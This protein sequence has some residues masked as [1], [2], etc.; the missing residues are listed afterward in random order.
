MTQNSENEHNTTEGGNSEQR[1]TDNIVR[2][3]GKSAVVIFL[4]TFLELGISLIT[5]LIIAQ[6]LV[7]A[8]YGEVSIGLTILLVTSIVSQLG[9]DT[10]IPRTIPRYEG[11]DRRGVFISAF[12]LNAI[13]SLILAGFVFIAA[14]FIADLLGNPA[15]KSVLRVVAFGVPAMPLMRLAISSTQSVGRSVPKVIVQNLLH[16][17]TRV[18]IIGATILLGATPV[19]VAGAYVVTNWIGAV[20]ACYF[21]VR[22]TRILNANIG[23]TPKHREILKYSL[24]LMATT[25]LTFILGNTD[26]LMIQYFRGSAE[27]GVYDIGYTIAQTLPFGLASLSYLFLPNISNLHADGEWSQITHL[28]KL[29]SKWVVFVTVPPFLLI[30]Y[31]PSILISHTFGTEYLNGAPYLV[32]LA[33]SYFVMAVTGPNQRALSAF[34]D[35]RAIF[36]VN[37]L[38]AGVNIT[39]NYFLL[40]LIGTL[41]AAIASS[42]SLIIVQLLYSYRLYTIY[43]ISPFSWALMKPIGTFV[44]VTITTYAIVRMTIG[45]PS[46]LGIIPVLMFA[47]ILY[48]III[49]VFGGIQEDDIM[50]VRSAEQSLGIN[51]EPLKRIARRFM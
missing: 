47:G 5:K 28:Y 51:L 38:A 33:I 26:T 11:S 29:V 7:P 18:I 30:S 31:F 9:F 37:A 44:I 6:Q 42:V 17:I 13:I 8:N 27:V 3:L 46:L 39:L 49:I 22:H 15:L 50:L 40:I 34:G 12:Q 43:N 20:A 14:G 25:G 24:P 41:G 35:T 2:A 1:D 16:P 23:W 48:T 19:T 4:G 32:I 10:G 45:L 36:L 21:L